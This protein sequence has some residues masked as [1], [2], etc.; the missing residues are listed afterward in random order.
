MP[1][2]INIYIKNTKT[3]KE[4]KAPCMSQKDLF[5]LFKG[6]REFLKRI[7]EKAL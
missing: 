7:K 6:E 4:W 2:L 1:I 5:H 3:M